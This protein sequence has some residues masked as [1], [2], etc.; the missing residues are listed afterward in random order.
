MCDNKGDVLV[1]ITYI[2]IFVMSLPSSVNGGDTIKNCRNEP[3]ESLKFLKM[4]W[5]IISKKKS[6]EPC[7][8]DFAS[9]AVVMKFF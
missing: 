7:Y 9:K 8:A 3:G 1:K 2:A 4:S 6:W 5:E